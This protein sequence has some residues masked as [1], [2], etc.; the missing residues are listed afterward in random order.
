M[1]EHALVVSTLWFE[2]HGQLQIQEE[3]L[4]DANNL[5]HGVKQP[6]NP[7]SDGP[8][9]ITQCPIQPGNNFTYEIV[10][11]NEI[12]SWFKVDVQQL[13]EDTLASGGRP[14]TSNAFTINGQPGDLYPCSSNGTSKFTVEFGKTYL[15][16]IVNG[17]MN[18]NM[19][20]EVANH[21]LTVVGLDGA[22]VKPIITNYIMT[23]PGQTMDVLITANQPPSHYYMASRAYAGVEYDETTT[24]AIFKYKGNYSVPSTIPFPNLPNYTDHAAAQNFVNRIRAL[25][26]TEHPVNVPQM[27]DKRLLITI[28]LNIAPCPNNTCTLGPNGNNTRLSASL[29]NV[30]FHAPSID[31]LQA[32]YRKIPGIFETDFPLE[33]Q[34]F[35]FTADRTPSNAVAPESATKVKVINFNSS[36]EIV[37]Q[38]TNVLNSAENHPLHL[39]GYSFYVVGYGDGNF[40]NVTSPSTYNLVDPPE[41]NTVAVP[42][43]GWAAV[44]FKADNPGVWFM[45]CH[46]ER[47][48][49]WGMETV[50]IVKDGKHKLSKMR[51]PPTYLNP[52]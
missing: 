28:S 21:N 20:L 34:A 25:A 4:E 36:V 13:I 51:K 40:N 50:L 38:G 48:S 44:R 12:G 7:W 27:V 2:G 35:N 37:F 41:M 47:H 39:H 9:Y 24:T 26:S 49:S 6:R 43:N 11:S 8:E 15:L 31:L 19:F 17:V 45:H 18:E 3:A 32:Y 14:N 46:F 33:P 23:T 1:R 29:S 42:R 52:C 30:S 5:G 16:R 22:Y 10:L